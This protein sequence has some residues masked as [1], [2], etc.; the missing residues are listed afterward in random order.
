MRNRGRGRNFGRMLV[1]TLRGRGIE[2]A[3]V[4]PGQSAVD[5]ARALDAG[6]RYRDRNG[7]PL[8]AV[9]RLLLQLAI[10]NPHVDVLTDDS[11]LYRAVLAECGSG[12]ASRVLSD[13][14]GR[15]NMTACFLSRVLKSGFIDC[16]PVRDAIE[17]RAGRSRPGAVRNRQNRDDLVAEAHLS[18]GCAAATYGPAFPDMKRGGAGDVVP[19]LLSF[20]RLA[21]REWYCACGDANWAVF[22][23]EWGRTERDLGAVQTAGKTRRP[24]CDAAKDIL[25]R[26]RGCYCAC[27]R[28]GE[29][30]LH[31]KFKAIMSTD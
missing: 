7:E 18:P 1:Q 8:S 30:G 14:F 10:E 26:Y 13:Y 15:L 25:D 11:A 4:R 3:A 31:E 21:V 28:P 19:T 17:Y 5:G 24:Y 23:R 2:F 20:V 27:S 12:R 16:I 29:R 9:D 22:D 6:G